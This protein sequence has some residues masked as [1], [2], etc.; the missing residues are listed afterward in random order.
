MSVGT[1]VGFKDEQ[2]YGF[3]RP[4]DGGGDVFVHARNIANADKL[5]QG[6][7]VSFETV[8]DEKRGKLRADRV[9]VI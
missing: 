3:I 1:V 2:G 8:T 6:Q 4:D 7:R 9:R 5:N